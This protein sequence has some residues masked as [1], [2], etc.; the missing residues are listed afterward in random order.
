MPLKPLFEY[1]MRRTFT[2]KNLGML[3]VFVGLYTGLLMGLGGY[4]KPAQVHLLNAPYIQSHY[5]Y[6]STFITNYALIA[7]ASWISLSLFQ[8]GDEDIALLMRTSRVQMWGVK[9]LVGLGFMGTMTT[10]LL[11]INQGMLVT[12]SLEHSNL[13]KRI[14]SQGVTV[15]YYFSGFCLI[16][17]FIKSPRQALFVMPVVFAVDTF[18]PSIEHQET[19]F[20]ASLRLLFPMLEVSGNTDILAPTTWATLVLSG[21]NV[22]LNFY[23]MKNR[24]Y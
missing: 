10:I 18:L 19:L 1:E 11:S 4:F 21:L 5:L 2:K 9:T 12:L 14:F 3:T 16:A 23:A 20:K 22:V 17:V 13:L 15:V 8:R 6:Y 7:W 24:N